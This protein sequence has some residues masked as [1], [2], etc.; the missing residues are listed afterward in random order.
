M[1]FRIGIMKSLKR[2]ILTLLVSLGLL[3]PVFSSAPAGAADLFNGAK[4]EACA[5]V[6]ATD[7]SGNCD[8]SDNGPLKKSEGTL[9]QTLTTLLNLL[10]VVVGLMSVIMIIISGIRFVTSNGDSN[11]ITSA[12]NTFIYALVGLIITAFAQIIVKVV[13]TRLG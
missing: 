3:A 7:S 11:S 6:G 4:G 5:T 13:L 8:Y 9:S 10:T 2:N 12:R 1:S